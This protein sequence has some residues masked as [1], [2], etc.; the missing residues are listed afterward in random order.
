MMNKVARYKGTGTGNK[1]TV[2]PGFIYTNKNGIT[3]I[4]DAK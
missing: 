3:F 1:I 2:E 4:S